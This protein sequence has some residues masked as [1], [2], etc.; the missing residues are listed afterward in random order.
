M[1]STKHYAN[2]LELIQYCKT[3][4]DT[5]LQCF[6][7]TALFLKDSWGRESFWIKDHSYIQT[8]GGRKLWNSIVRNLTHSYVIGK[9]NFVVRNC[10]RFY[11]LLK[12]SKMHILKNSWFICHKMLNLCF[13]ISTSVEKQKS[14]NMRYAVLQLET[15]KLNQIINW[16]WTA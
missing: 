2:S 16:P 13:A 8:I 12:C 1:E 14:K 9:N 5:E 7:T 15:L 3:A 11:W 6:I 4:F 10:V